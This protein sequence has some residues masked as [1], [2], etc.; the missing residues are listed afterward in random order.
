MDLMT[1]AAKLVL[2]DSGFRSGINAAESQGRGLTKSLSAMTVAAGNIMA[3]VLKK[4]V[5]TVKN[6]VGE[7]IGA[8]ADYQQLIGGVETLFK[9]SA[10]QVE[11]YAK[12]SFRT[13]GLSANDY[14]ETVTGFSASLLQGL[15]GD[16]AAAADLANTAIQ[17]MADNAN[18][19]GTDMSSIQV[20]YQGF[21]KQNYTMLDNLKLGYG[22]TKEEMIRLVNDSGILDKKIKSLDGIT[23]DQLIEAIHA[24]QTEMGITGT[25]AEEAASTISGS[26]ASLKAAWQDLLSAVGGE[27]DQ[28]RLEETMENFKKSFQTYMEN[29]IPTLVTTISNSGS[30]VEAIADSIASLP[31]D[32]LSKV[33]QGALKTGTSLVEGA[34]S[35]THWLIESI[36]NTFK[37]ASIDSTD[38]ENFGSALGTFLGSTIADIAKN[39]PAIIT[40]AFDA[41]V[42]LAGSFLEGLFSGIFGTGNE[43]DKVNQQLEESLFSIDKQTTHAD[44]ILDYMDKLIQKYGDGA[45]ETQE[46]KTAQGELEEI[47]KGASGVFEEYGSDI[48]G[49]VNKLHAMNEELRQAAVMDALEKATSDQFALLTEQTLAYNQ[50]KARYEMAESSQQTYKD[51]LVKEIQ[52]A[53]QRQLDEY[54]GSPLTLAQKDYYDHLK[55]IADGAAEAGTGLAKLSELDFSGLEALAMSLGDETIENNIKSIHQLY[56]EAE[57]TMSDS[58]GKMDD[59]KKEMDATSE[60]I[61]LTKRAMDQ[62]VQ[63]LLGSGTTTGKSIESAGG[64]VAS[65]LQQVSAMIAAAGGGIKRMSGET[66]WGRAWN[67]VA[68]NFMPRAV[69]IDYVPYDGFLTE[70]HKGERVVTRQENERYGTMDYAAMEGALQ[71]AIEDS[72]RGMYFNLNGDRVADLTTRRTQQN[73]S[74]SSRARTRGM[75]G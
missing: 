26:K 54:D 73:I 48:Q 43:V 12:Q 63:D 23:F 67:Y 28:A 60:S 56:Q 71:R 64:D 34:G 40:G 69:G 10:G 66:V 46:W 52:A 14:M 75:G 29:F 32:L 22:G 45:K 38:I 49:A 30:L 47:L 72:V 27:G 57:N 13:T 7:S 65:A 9:T 2:D 11:A 1:I 35:I 61:E 3:D 21:A 8:Y 5:S 50:E 18:K 25:T 51:K 4:T 42:A 62:T 17:D 16:T 20:A 68:D 59:A 24:I 53:A 74:A 6:I 58:K 70:L 36:A 41:G 19:M 33:G 37:T 44:A 31:T 55:L 39:A 15:K